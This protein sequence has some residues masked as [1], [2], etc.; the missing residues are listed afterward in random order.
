VTTTTTAFSISTT[1]SGISHHAVAKNKNGVVASSNH[2]ADANRTT[3]DHADAVASTELL[4]TL[5]A[6]ATNAALTTDGTQDPHTAL[7][8]VDTTKTDHAEDPTVSVESG[9]VKTNASTSRT[10]AHKNATAATSGTAATNA[11]A[12]TTIV[13]TATNANNQPSAV[14][15]RRSKF[16]P[17]VKS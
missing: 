11:K 1:F 9:E 16:A 7:A 5:D 15:A 6:L 3:M 14:D 4:P 12:A 2:H 17:V 13:T 8:A 10:T